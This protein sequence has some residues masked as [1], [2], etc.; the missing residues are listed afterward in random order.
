MIRNLLLSTLLLFIAQNALAQ[1]RVDDLPTLLPGKTEMQ[2]GLWVETPLDRQFISSKTVVVADIKGPATI[3]MIHFALPMAMKLNR[4][5]LLQ[6]LLGRREGSERRLPAG[7][8][9]LR[10]G[11]PEG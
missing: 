8:F 2:N 4:D 5:V 9:L 1:V 6:D 10:S 7:R 11:G 3:T